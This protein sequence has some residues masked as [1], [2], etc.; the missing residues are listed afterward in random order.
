[1]NEASSQQAKP[2]TEPHRHGPFAID[3]FPERAR[4][5]QAVMELLND[6]G[7]EEATVEMVLERAGVEQAAFEKDFTDLEDC[8]M[9]IYIANIE[10]FD[11]A[12][13]EA[14]DRHDRWRDRLRGAAYA[15]ARW[16]QS[17]PLQTRFDMVHMLSAGDMAQ[18]HRDRHLGRIVDLIDEG[19]QELHDPDSM[20]R[21]VAV[22]IFG[23]IYQSVLKKT[24]DERLTSR[25]PESFVPD[26]MYI[27]VRPYLGHE[28]AHEELTIPAPPEDV[29]GTPGA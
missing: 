10:E 19:R 25:P 21:D 16:I 6:H 13:F 3:A 12:V 1:M 22:G 5:R 8:C 23:S 15:A 28:V 17:H 26:L 14:A 4:V 18:V 7:L 27:A 24:H 9:Q 29:D 11:R 2:A 20:T